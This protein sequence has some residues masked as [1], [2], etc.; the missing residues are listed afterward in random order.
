MSTVMAN[1]GNEGTPFMSEQEVKECLDSCTTRESVS[2]SLGF[3]LLNNRQIRYDIFVEKLFKKMDL[4]LMFCHAA[5]GC[6]EEAGELSDVIKRDVIYNSDKTSE[7]KSILEGIIEEIGDV[8]FYLQAVMNLY[9]ISEQQVL[10]HNALKLAERYEGLEY[11]DA[12]AQ[13]R[14]DKNGKEE[15]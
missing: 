1:Q 2:A 8:R 13:A 3:V 4:D 5:M 12:A 11:R 7:G 15:A 10:Q 6:A 14:A 9:G